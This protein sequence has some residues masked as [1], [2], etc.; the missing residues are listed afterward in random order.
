MNIVWVEY[1][2]LFFLVSIYNHKKVKGLHGVPFPH[3]DI[4]AKIYGKDKATRKVS[5]TSIDVVKNIKV[6]MANEPIFLDS[7]DDNGGESNFGT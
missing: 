6:E 7:D 1:N 4:L 2:I 3:F 5:E